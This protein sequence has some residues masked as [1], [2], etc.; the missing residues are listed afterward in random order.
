MGRFY[1]VKEFS[2]FIVQE[3]KWWMIPLIAILLLLGLFIVV[4]ESSPL[5]PFLYPLF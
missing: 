1:I 5:A 2:Q 3:K 4:A